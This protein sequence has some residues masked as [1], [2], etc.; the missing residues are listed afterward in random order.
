MNIAPAIA[1]DLALH[2]PTAAAISALLYPHGEVVLHDLRSGT[3][4]A[5]WNCF[6]GRTVGEDSL[7]EEAFT[8]F[9][10]KA[11]VLGPYEKTGADGQRFKS[12]SAVL[13]NE[14]G[15]AVGLLC[16]NLDVSMIDTALKLL[17][18][19]AGAEQPRPR[20]L[21][22]RDWRE[23][24]NATL[25]GWLGER[26]LALSA[27]KRGDRVALVAALD[28]RG[29]FQTRNAVD[30]LAS[31]IGASRASIYNYLAAARGEAPG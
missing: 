14:T 5:I 3:I 7:I 24:I 25:H 22:A 26:G 28:E 15:E 17:S 31:L 27:L 2:A 9:G 8:A 21:F 16:I 1:A 10:G 29:L 18:A 13:R 30:H 12:I 11:V 6:S 23:E 19:F 4:A 20:A